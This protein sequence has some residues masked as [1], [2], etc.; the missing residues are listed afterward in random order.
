LVADIVHLAC[1][2]RFLQDRSYGPGV[3][4]GHILI[5]ALFL[6]DVLV[7]LFQR[8]VISPALASQ[9]VRDLRR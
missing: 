5:D 3:A 8:E 4:R 1:G 6:A 7:E 2:H 9:R